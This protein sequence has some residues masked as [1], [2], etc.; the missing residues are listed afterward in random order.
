MSKFLKDRKPHKNHYKPTQ[1]VE[2][3]MVQ[4]KRDIDNMYDYRREQEHKWHKSTR[5][6]NMLC[7]D[8][9]HEDN[10]FSFTVPLS[11]MV[12]SQGIVSMRQ[13]L[14]DL[15][16]IPGGLDDK[17]KANILRE[18]NA[19]VD[20]MCNME[21]V[22]D[23]GIVDF[24][25]LGNMV[26]QDYF[27]V[28]YKTRRIKQEDGSYKDTI[29][30]DWSRS[31]IGTRALSPWECA[32]DHTAR[33]PAQVR[34]CTWRERIP[35]DVFQE[36]FVRIPDYVDDLGYINTK[37]VEPGVKYTFN[38]THKL[39]REEDDKEDNDV[40]IDHYQNEI[41]D[42]WRIY[43][44]GVLIWDVALSE[45]HAHERCTLT[46]VPN[47]HKYDKNGKTH[48]L[49]GAGDPELIE[50]MDDLLN[51]MYS[52]FIYNYKQKNVNVIGIEGEG[53]IDLDE[54][55]FEGN[56]VI[57]GRINIQALGQADLPEF[58][59]FKTDIE[60]MA[61]QMAKKNYKLLQDD[62]SKTAFE[63]QQKQS[64]QG[65]GMKYQVSRMESGGF[66]EHARK[67]LSD[68]MEHLTAEEYEQITGEDLKRI[69][70]MLGEEIATQDL[71]IDPKTKE[72]VA[73][74]RRERIRTRGFVLEENAGKSG[75]RD[76]NN[77]TINKNFSGEDGYLTAA[78]E[79]LWTREYIM[80]R[81]IPDLYVVGKTMFGDDN[82]T[83]QAQ[84]DQ[85]LALVQGEQQV[86]PDSPWDM[87]K[88]IE[89]YMETVDLEPEKY[90]K[91]DMANPEKAQ[92][93]SRLEE[94]EQAFTS[95]PQNPNDQGTNQQPQ[96]QSNP[97]AAAIGQEAPQSVA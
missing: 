50:D 74:K 87:T 47:H 28:P 10:E 35:F 32:F 54:L 16:I 80:R 53:S 15:V 70:D 66:Y 24:G 30:R 67:R 33:T 85:V 96:T 27:E 13:A 44:N 34:K 1:K 3:N 90:K 91:E 8:P 4:D 9:S 45:V 65:Q 38:Q 69:K 51:A 93:Q 60:E 64:L 95:I 46:L 89:Q 25:V 17:K 22:M 75:K 94:I 40:I 72:P 76:I 61:I 2:R 12:T 68:I 23:Y 81:G 36:R 62:G 29:V 97:F 56:E 82:I 37:Y 77:V 88:S 86:N 26:L 18:A 5:K 55:V 58:A 21:A 7:S 19:H 11:R 92:R 39:D 57:Q 20:R 79:Y 48:C 42:V 59:N 49:Y 6:W 78:P 52:Q 43:A 63:F 31:K 84:L 41:L 71:V 73:I 14:P 83:K